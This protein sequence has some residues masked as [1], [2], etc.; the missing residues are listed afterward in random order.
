MYMYYNLCRSTSVLFFYRQKINVVQY[1]YTLSCVCNDRGVFQIRRIAEDRRNRIIVEPRG[2]E[3][4]I[5]ITSAT[6]AATVRRR[7]NVS[8]TINNNI[9]GWL[10]K[11][12]RESLP[13]EISS[14]VARST[15]PP[16]RCAPPSPSYSHLLEISKFSRAS[17]PA[18]SVDDTLEKKLRSLKF[19]F[20]RKK[21]KLYGR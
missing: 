8:I 13:C 3:F 2:G 19:Y 7:I 21:S 5:M 4:Q 18:G 11:R 14:P 20:W 9:L 15:L 6:Y 16:N 17:S 12:P 10:P 1:N